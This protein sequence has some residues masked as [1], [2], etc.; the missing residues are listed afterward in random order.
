MSKQCYLIHDED[1]YLVC[2]VNHR[3]YVNCVLQP[4]TEKGEG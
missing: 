4:T 1:G 3:N 2:T